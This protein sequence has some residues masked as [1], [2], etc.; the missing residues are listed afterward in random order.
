VKTLYIDHHFIARE[1]KG[2]PTNRQLLTEL[3]ADDPDWRLAASESN[4]LEI[5][6]DGDKARALRRAQFLDSLHPVWMM[7][8]LD[9]QKHE[10]RAFLWGN[11]FRV[12][13]EPLSPFRKHLSEVMSYHTRPIIG[14]GAATWI[15]A[16]DPTEIAEAKRLTVQSLTILQ[17]ASKQQ[18]R[19]IEAVTFR[20]WV[21]PKIP[22]RDP[23]GALMS[24]AQK[25]K[26][27]A[28]CYASRDQ[29]FRECPAIAVEHY[30]CEAR[31]RD[32]NRVPEEA[33]AI[34]LQHGVLGLSYCDSFVTGDRYSY[35]TA[36]HAIKSL[37]LLKLATPYRK[38][39]EAPINHTPAPPSTAVIYPTARA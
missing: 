1:T 37:P 11:H 21:Y 34:D 13:A 28:L 39:E 25:D 18:K 31:T 19:Q 36:T 10:V 14:A 2:Q 33:D 12:A 32:P 38:L 6:F 7:E 4:L 24:K 22:I 8:R 26:L 17:A 15:R 23:A 27:A 9:I 16:I 35:S 20:A 30:I 3:L 5:A 29:F